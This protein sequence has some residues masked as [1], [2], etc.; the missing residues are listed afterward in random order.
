MEAGVTASGIHRGLDNADYNL[1]FKKDQNDRLHM[2]ICWIRLLQRPDIEKIDVRVEAD[3]ENGTGST[4][5][6]WISGQQRADWEQQ[7]ELII[8]GKLG[9]LTGKL[10]FPRSLSSNTASVVD[11]YM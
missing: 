3:T 9:E 6:F 10:D 5:N 7:V 4:R 1:V 8:K 2:W 11:R